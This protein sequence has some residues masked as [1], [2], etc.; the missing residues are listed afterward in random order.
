MS[1]T[2]LGKHRRKSTEQDDKDEDKDRPRKKQKLNTDVCSPVFFFFTRLFPF[3][4]A[5]FFPF[6]L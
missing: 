3:F 5:F 1:K 4:Y 2:N 6:L